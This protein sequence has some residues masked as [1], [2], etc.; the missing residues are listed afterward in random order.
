MFR[1]KYILILAVV[2][3]FPIGCNQ[4][5]HEKMKETTE[6][7]LT[8]LEFVIDWLPEPTYL[9]V[10]YAIDIGEF[11]KA[12][13]LT[14]VRVI[15]GA[16]KVASFVGRQ[17][18][19]V[20]IA[21]GAATVLQRGNKGIPVKSLGVLYEDIPSVV[22]GITP[23]TMAIKPKDL[24]GMKIGIWEGSVTNNEFTA[25]IRA[26]NLDESK[27]NKIPI[28]TSESYLLRNGIIDAVL[29]YNEMVPAYIDINP[30]MPEIAG[31]KPWRILLRDHGVK[32]YGVNLITSDKAIEQQ[33]E[34]LNKIAQAVYNGYQKACADQNDAVSK[35]IERFPDKNENYVAHSYA[36]VCEQLTQP[37]GFQTK[38]GWQ[39]TI[40]LYVNLRVLEKGVLKPEDVFI[41]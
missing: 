16:D 17:K 27:I 39:N 4:S 18:Y 29:H 14:T 21:S 11:E 30:D 8:P 40:D 33:G 23:R 1:K 20:G 36:I 7:D 32:G 34:E 5:N 28:N 38:E 6:D 41:E 3:I 37:I 10:Y 13:Y 31:K 24:E 25:F 15:Q 35:F 2:F 22:Y 9:G 26:N 19:L 12:G